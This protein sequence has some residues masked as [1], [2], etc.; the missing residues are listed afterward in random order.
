MRA[1]KKARKNPRR[2]KRRLNTVGSHV[3]DLFKPGMPCVHCGERFQQQRVGTKQ[4]P[5]VPQFDY[6]DNP[7][8]PSRARHFLSSR[9]SVPAQQAIIP[10][11]RIDDEDE[12]IMREVHSAAH[13]LARN[14]LTGAAGDPLPSMMS[15]KAVSW[16]SKNINKFRALVK[17]ASEEG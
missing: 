13:D 3:V 6:Q 17:I 15:A 7:M 12:R 1:L 11:Y 14:G 16:V 4:N 10:E 5:G 9:G 2:H 8:T